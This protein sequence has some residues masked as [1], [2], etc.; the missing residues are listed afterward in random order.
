MTESLKNKTV[1]GVVWSG[2][3]RF[4]TI[5]IQAIVNILLARLLVPEDFGLIAEILI[6][7]QIANLLIDSGFSTALIQRKDRNETDFTTVFYFNIFVSIILYLTLFL[8]ASLIANF[9]NEPR[10]VAIVRVVSINF[11]IGALMAIHKTRLTIE[12][13]FKIQSAISIV[14]AI[15]AGIM[16][17]FMAYSGYG[18]WALV[19]QS[20]INFSVQ[21][22]LMNY[23]IRWLPRGG[24]SFQAFKSLWSYSS[25]CLG[26]AMLHQLYTILYPII[27]GKRFSTVELGFYNRGDYFSALPAQ[28]LGNVISRVAFPIFSTIQ[29]DPERLRKAYT[30]YIQFSSAIIFPIMTIFMALAYSGI[31]LFLTEKWLPCAPIFQILCLAWMVDHISQINLNVLYVTGRSDLALK[32]E[33]IKKSIAVSILLVSMSFGIYAIC[34][35]RVLYSIIAIFINAHYTNGLIG[36]SRLRQFLDFTPFL[37]LA[38]IAG[39]IAFF[40]QLLVDYNLTK[41]IIGCFMGFAAYVFSVFLFKRQFFSEFRAILSSHS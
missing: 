33:V 35:G 15:I 41:V 18:V 30:K 9:F 28:T 14:A 8:S 27:I 29:D 23:I 17:V 16:S 32:L 20:L 19:A 10:L 22:I 3:E 4:A 6:F 24:F 12:L 36:I 11:V 38:F 21:C 7:I 5:A 25:K 34:W 1:N 31:A 40:S 13:R 26:S 39:G 2:V 37:F